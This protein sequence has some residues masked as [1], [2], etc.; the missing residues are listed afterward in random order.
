MW[1]NFPQPPVRSVYH[2]GKALCP[3]WLPALFAVLA[4]AFALSAESAN[5]SCRKGPTGKWMC[6]SPNGGDAAASTG[7]DAAPAPAAAATAPAESKPA[8]TAAPA[9]AAPAPAPA[10][11]PQKPIVSERPAEPVAPAASAPAPAPAP[12]SPPAVAAPQKTAPPKPAAPEPK[13]TQATPAPQAASAPAAASEPSTPASSS[14][15]GWICRGGSGKPG[16][17]GWACGPDTKGVARA[18]ATKGKSAYAFNSVDEARFRRMIK[19]MGGDP[20]AASCAGRLPTSVLPSNYGDRE[21]TALETDSDYLEA[22]DN[23]LYTFTGGVDLVRADQRLLGDYVLHDKVA[24]T[25]NAHG[26]VVYRE[27]GTTVGADTLFMQLDTNQ[28]KLRNTQYIFEETPARGKAETTYFDGPKHSRHI[29]AT[30]TTCKPGNDDWMV[31]ASRLRVDKDTGR[32][33][34]SNA[35]IE[36]KGVPFFYTPWISFAT[37]KRRQSG[38]LAP[39]FAMSSAMGF[40]FSM[41]YYWN[42]APNYDLTLFPRYSSMHG[43][44]LGTEFRYMEPNYHGYFMG[45]IIPSDKPKSVTSSNVDQTNKV[46]LPK[47]RGFASFVDDRALLSNV[48]SN[49][50]LNYV[51]D[52]RYFADMWNTMYRHDFINRA[53]LTSSATLNYGQSFGDNYVYS[54]LFAA[55]YQLLVDNLPAASKPYR[56]APM[57]TFGFSRPLGIAGGTFTLANEL[58]NF[59]HDARPLIQRAN[60]KP[61]ISFPWK[62]SWGFLMPKLSL[63]QTKYWIN[64]SVAQTPAPSSAAASR[65]TPIFSVDSGLQFDRETDW[66]GKSYVQTLEPRLFY[67]YVPYTN[68]DNI[69]NITS[70]LYDF[71]FQSLFRENRFTGLDRMGDANQASAA[72]TTRMVDQATGREKMRLSLGKMIEFT[73]PKV[74][75]VKTEGLSPALQAYYASTNTYMASRN[76]FIADATVSVTDHI[77][78]SPLVL[79][80]YTKNYADRFQATVH[81]NAG[82]NRLLNLGYRYRRN[83]VDNSDVSW[84]WPVT[85][86]WSVVGRWQYAW[87]AKTTLESFVGVQKETCCWKFSVVAREYMTGVALAGGG[88]VTDSKAQ[89]P[90]AQGVFL[91]LELKGF[92]NIGDSVND[93]YVRSIPGFEGDDDKVRTP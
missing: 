77:K 39:N 19:A 53:Y 63:Q 66:F 36:F 6:A 42:I 4:L 22:E 13:L 5:W 11:A 85:D 7:A 16:K 92:A 75:L 73:N 20:W 14:G 87:Q 28:G 51:T 46:Q 17:K 84:S 41:P 35:W 68:Q 56:Y 44:I 60:I 48:S 1:Q 81:Y 33:V 88:T 62:E 86:E 57:W 50:K 91:S 23:E 59:D 12:A 8:E 34:A 2:P 78:L 83:L 15:S 80:N 64:N 82:N 71:N 61:T 27:T 67:L 3:R 49:V 43:L 21:S 90:M 93:F 65:T 52:N 18:P 69:I 58:T 79:W 74:V 89:S 54:Q 45:Q 70:A 72:L 47:T 32:G 38:F 9:V 37:D 30:F 55:N 24:H 29:K 10:P 25:L 31:H 40:G 76:D 26:N